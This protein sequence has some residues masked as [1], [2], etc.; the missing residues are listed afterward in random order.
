MTVKSTPAFLGEMPSIIAM[1]NARDALSWLAR[2]KESLVL[3]RFMAASL[4]E[5]AE[6]SYSAYG[7]LGM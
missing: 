3:I 2:E 7:I 6:N 5:F 1:Y 4:E